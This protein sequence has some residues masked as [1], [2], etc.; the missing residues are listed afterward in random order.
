[1]RHDD[2]LLTGSVALTQKLVDAFAVN[3]DV[4]IVLPTPPAKAVAAETAV[5]QEEL[6]NKVTDAASDRVKVKVG[7]KVLPSVPGAIAV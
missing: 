1:L 6:L 7:V 5:E 3:E 2:V 4:V